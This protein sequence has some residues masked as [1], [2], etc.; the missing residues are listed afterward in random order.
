MQ[1]AYAR[2]RIR[3]SRR[4]VAAETV[5]K[6]PPLT[7]ICRLGSAT[8]ELLAFYGESDPHFPR[9]NF[10]LGCAAKGTK[11]VFTDRHADACPYRVSVE[12]FRTSLKSALYLFSL[13]SGKMVDGVVVLMV[14]GRGRGGA[15][16]RACVRACVCV[17]ECACVPACVLF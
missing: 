10:P 2:Q 13:F 11:Y 6:I 9:D 16:V 5:F 3:G 15:C 1:Q 7:E 17:C 12:N 4:N 8:L 14:W